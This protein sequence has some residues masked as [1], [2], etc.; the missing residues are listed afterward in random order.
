MSVSVIFPDLWWHLL[1]NKVC[2]AYLSVVRRTC[3]STWDAV[4]GDE[5]SAGNTPYT[6]KGL[7]EWRMGMLSSFNLFNNLMISL[8]NEQALSFQ[9][10][11]WLLTVH[12]FI[13][14]LVSKAHNSQLSSIS[15]NCPSLNN[16]VIISPFD[17]LE[18][19]PN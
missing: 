19:L 7:S 2:A 16:S 17:F 12:I 6:G 13:L 15:V 5:R 11:P 8:G 9:R 10:I 18:A 1:I 14:P 4:Q 3:D